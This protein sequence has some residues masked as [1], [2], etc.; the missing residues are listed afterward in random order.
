MRLSAVETLRV[1]SSL[2]LFPVEE[3][4][5]HVVFHCSMDAEAALTPSHRGGSLHYCN[6]LFSTVE[7]P[8]TWP[9]LSPLS[10]AVSLT[11]C[12]NRL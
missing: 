2:L 11:G 5:S 7:C 12:A 8:H 6:P 10:A 4:M 3:T 1:G 9:R